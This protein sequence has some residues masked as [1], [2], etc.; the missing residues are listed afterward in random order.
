MKN[1]KSFLSVLKTFFIYLSFF[2]PIKKN[3]DKLY[4]T[5]SDNSG[6]TSKGLYLNLGLWSEK[7]ENLD[8][9]SVALTD[10][11]AQLGKLSPEHHLLDVGFGFA[12]QTLY[13]FKNYKPK[14]I[15]GI[16]ICRSQVE[17][18]SQR[19]KSM[20]LDSAIELQWGSATQLPF[21]DQQFDRIFVLEA[22]MHFMPRHQFFKEAF[23]VLKPGGQLIMADICGLTTS[24]NFKQR[25]I[26]NLACAFW[27]LDKAN[28]YPIETYQH[29]LEKSG[30]EVTSLDSIKDNVYPPCFDFLIKKLQDNAFYQSLHPFYR[31]GAKQGLRFTRHYQAYPFDYVLCVAKKT[32]S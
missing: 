19:I 1:L 29:H 31:F 2:L 30:F 7:T 26:F 9:A 23:R 21:Q 32:I 24:L 6:F 14:K 11:L 4:D 16:N 10:K 5:L 8:D 15:S 13:W 28:L 18:A 12:E 17:Y 20:N 25:L 22:A 3:P 27:N